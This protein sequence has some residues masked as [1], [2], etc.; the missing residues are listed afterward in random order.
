MSRNGNNSV[1][2]E[3]EYAINYHARAKRIRIKVNAL[4]NVGVVAP[5]GASSVEIAYFVK[6]NARW[7]EKTLAKLKDDRLNHIDLG[8][9][10]PQNITLTA[11]SK[12]LL[13]NY[14][15]SSDRRSLQETDSQLIVMA[16]SDDERVAL[17]RQW[18]QQKAKQRLVPWLHEVSSQHK[19]KFNKVTIRGQKTRWG[20]CSNKKN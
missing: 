8:L 14:S 11:L 6:K 18:L 15:S 9:K 3:L 10:P 17:L 13:V 4:G 16:N 20:S 5:K 1:T 7:I 19:I 2:K 12:K